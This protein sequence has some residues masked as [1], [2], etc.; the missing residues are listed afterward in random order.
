MATGVVRAAI[1]AVMEKTPS[2]CPRSSKMK[3]WGQEILDKACQDGSSCQEAFDAFSA[4]L[5]SYINDLIASTA[6]RYKSTN[7]KR[8]HLWSEFHKIRCNAKGSLHLMWKEMTKKFGTDEDDR[9]PL[10]EQS[11]YQEF[12]S[13]CVHNYFS[14]STADELNVMRYV[15]G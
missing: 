2:Q 7:V 11:V 9:D 14:S 12:F 3:K 6:S 15:S 1:L 5:H 10:L 13:V 8:Q 4:K